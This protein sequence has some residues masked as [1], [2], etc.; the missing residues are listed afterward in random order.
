MAPVESVRPLYF[1][2]VM[3]PA[4]VAFLA[5][6]VPVLVRVLLRM[7]QAQA[8][9][10]AFLLALALCCLLLYVDGASGNASLLGLLRRTAAGFCPPLK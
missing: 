3:L 6:G 7:K 1:A 9:D 5:V 4:L 8:R 2:F 10:R